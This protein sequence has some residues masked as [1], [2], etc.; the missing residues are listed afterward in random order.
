MQLREKLPYLCS[1]IW[2]HHFS[3]PLFL[4]STI[5]EKGP[6]DDSALVAAEQLAAELEMEEKQEI[7]ARLITDLE[8]K[9][10]H[11]EDQLNQTEVSHELFLHWAVLDAGFS[12]L[13][14]IGIFDNTVGTPNKGQLI[15]W[16]NGSNKGIL[17]IPLFNIFSKWRQ[18]REF[19]SYMKRHFLTMR[20]PN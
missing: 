18:I 19:S 7:M 17:A 15:F 1:L 3:E 16:K 10:T 12:A 20:V 4:G 13:L 11:L 14:E 5:S 2:T 9:N 8:L 6:A